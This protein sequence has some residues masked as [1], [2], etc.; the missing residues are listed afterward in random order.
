MSNP[1]Q[2]E[3]RQEQELRIQQQIAFASELFQGDVTI[4]RLLESLAQGVVVVDNSG[5]ILLINTQAEIIF[6]YTKDDLIGKAHSLLIPERFR[7]VHEGH[8]AHFFEE[9][10]ARPMGIGLDLCGRRKD[11]SEF[12]VEISLSYIETI[13]GVL[14]IALIS[15]ITV[16]KQFELRLRESEELFRIQ[17]ESV[18]DYAIF[19]LDTQG[20]VLN[21]NAGAEYLKGYRAEE[22]I[23]KHFSCFYTE[24]E[25]NADT[26]ADQLEKT[27]AE[28]R[29]EDIGWRVRKDGSRFWADVIITAVR[30]EKGKLSGFS[31]VT[32]DITERKRA[33][34]EI[35]SLNNTLAAHAAELETVNRELETFNYTVAHDL[36]KPLAV[37]NGYAQVLTEICSDK[38]D[39]Q[40]KGYVKETYE[41]ALRMDRLIDALLNFSRVAHAEPKREH[42]NLCAISEEVASQLKLAEPERHVTFHIPSGI[43]AEADP[44]LLRV[45]L[46]NLL[47][48]AWKYT[49]YRE[50]GVIEFGATEI[51][52]K[53]AYFVRDNGLGFDPAEAE[54]LFAP[55]Q[56]L[57]SGKDVGGLGIGLATVDRIITRH[58]GKVW[59]E[60]KPGEGATFYFT[61]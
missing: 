30:D 35:K 25:R 48:N 14:V 22:I 19:M 38:L 11:G 20:N 6:G 15:D 17:V 34:E 59:A 37:I 47:G 58:G 43:A 32:R 42:V 29:I 24:E 45:V 4:R 53:L 51:D 33:E 55:F 16:R 40:C 18:K 36:R 44:D 31:K 49:S 46:G 12:P 3:A 61:V 2:E 21:W 8:M 41:G 57:E 60:G 10:S 56:R 13:H 39:D 54:K 26:P 27:A 23:G 28:G 7:K 52:G 50:E 1:R 5:T 9:A